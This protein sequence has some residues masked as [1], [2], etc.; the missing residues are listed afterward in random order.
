M[1]QF[2]M[3]HCREFKCISDKCRHS[4]CIGWD[5][6]VDFVTVGKYISEGFS[7]MLYTDSDG[8]VCLKKD[9]NGRCVMLT[10]SGLCSLINKTGGDDLL[11]EICRLHPRYFI[12]LADRR[13]MGLG[14]CCEEAA[15]LILTSTDKMTPV[16]TEDDGEM[17][18]PA[19]AEHAVFTLRCD[20]TEMLQDRRLPIG[21][22]MNNVCRRLGFERPDMDLEL[23]IERL[24]GFERLDRE[25]DGVLSRSLSDGVADEIVVEQLLCYFVYRYLGKSRNAE[26][27][28][29][30]WLF[31]T[32]CT[33][34][35][36]SLSNGEQNDLCE[37]ARG[38]SAEIE[39]SPDNLEKFLDCLSEDYE[40]FRE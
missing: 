25:W 16:E 14:L 29:L 32:A 18:E 7:E 33:E 28:I 34:I 26:E 40:V 11:G 21:I 31:A 4:C 39:Y 19:A 9:E 3:N 22:R 37:V 6:A 30:Y 24:K 38:F 36:C 35:I 15:R 10:D 12:E 17:T 20:I 13:E 23:W 1:K 27:L 8:D 5:I 2:E